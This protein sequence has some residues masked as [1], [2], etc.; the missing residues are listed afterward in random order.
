MT[1]LR[2]PAASLKN[3]FTESLLAL[4]SSERR[5][6]LPPPWLRAIGFPLFKPKTTPNSPQCTTLDYKPKHQ[7]AAKPIMSGSKDLGPSGWEELVYRVFIFFIS[8]LFFVFLL[9]KRRISL[10]GQS[11]EGRDD[12]SFAWYGQS[13]GSP[14]RPSAGTIHCAWLFSCV[15]SPMSRTRSCFKA[16]ES[17]ALQTLARGNRRQGLQ[18]VATASGVRCIP[19]LFISPVQLNRSGKA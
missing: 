7:A 10:F 18:W 6:G 11:K 3:R 13:S 17:G 1:K 12:C 19:P 14:G 9:L 8:V 15:G 16:P 4:R 2:N 5:R